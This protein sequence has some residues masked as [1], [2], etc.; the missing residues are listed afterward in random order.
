MPG[1]FVHW[2]SGSFKKDRRLLF[3]ADYSI[4]TSE[5]GVFIFYLAESIF[6]HG[7]DIRDIGEKGL[8]ILDAPFDASLNILNLTLGY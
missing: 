8:H 4:I 1:G 3:S 2:S 7:D 6:F 5:N